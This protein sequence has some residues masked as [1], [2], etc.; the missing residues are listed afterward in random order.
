MMELSTKRVVIMVEKCMMATHT[1]YRGLARESN[2][3][4]TTN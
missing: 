2:I 1:L 4:H 3:I